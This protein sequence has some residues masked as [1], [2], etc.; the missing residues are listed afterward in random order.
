MDGSPGR[1]FRFCFEENPVL[2]LF[3]LLPELQLADKIF[4]SWKSRSI[5]NRSVFNLLH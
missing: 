3:I 5:L 2:S 1:G 4:L